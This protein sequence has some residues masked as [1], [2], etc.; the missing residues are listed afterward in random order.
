MDKVV[1]SSVDLPEPIKCR[2]LRVVDIASRVPEASNHWY[3]YSSA[4]ID[5][6]HK[7]VNKNGLDQLVANV[8][9]PHCRVVRERTSEVLRDDFGSELAEIRIDK[10]ENNTCVE[11]LS[12]EDAF[13]Y[14][15]ELLRVSIFTYPSDQYD[16]YL[17]ESDVHTNDE[18]RNALT[19][20]N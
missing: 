10:Q 8:A 20:N 15:C 11:E 5:E 13:G 2:L 12:E 19:E 7:R 4:E 6:R 18:K 17:F 14:R 9:V 1:I 16:D 3:E